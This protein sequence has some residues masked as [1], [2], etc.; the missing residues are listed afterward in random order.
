MREPQLPVSSEDTVVV[1]AGKENRFGKDLLASYKPGTA[2]V[3]VTVTGGRGFDD[4]PGL[5]RWAWR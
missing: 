3:A 5:L 4:V 1:Q 2:K